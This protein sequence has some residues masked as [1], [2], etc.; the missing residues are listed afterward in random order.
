MSSIT[1][2]V[3]SLFR[4]EHHW[5]SV[6]FFRNVPIFH[7]LHSRQIGRLIQSMQKRTYRAGEILFEEGQVGKAVFIIESGK[8][9]LTRRNND[10]SPRRLGLVGSGQVLGEMALLEQMERTA[11]AKVVEDGVIYLLYSATLEALFVQQ[12]AIGVKLLRNMS[13][14]LSALLRRTNQELDKLGENR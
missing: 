13:V 4:N 14:M 11:T 7:G 3:K 5:Q 12:P 1:Q 8:V 9:E 10:G 2:F 6:A